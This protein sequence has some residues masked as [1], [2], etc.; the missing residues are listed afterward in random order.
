[1]YFRCN[2]DKAFRYH[3]FPILKKKGDSECL[4]FSHP[5]VACK[6]SSKTGGADVKRQQMNVLTSFIDASQIYGIENSLKL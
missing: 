5:K 2:D 3:N 1:M 4:P 6:D